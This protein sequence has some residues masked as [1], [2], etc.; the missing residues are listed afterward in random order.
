[1]KYIKAMSLALTV[2]CLYMNCTK[3]GD[4]LCK[5]FRSEIVQ[6][7]SSVLRAIGYGTPPY[8]YEWSTGVHLSETS[9]SASGTYFVVVTD[10]NNCTA[11]SEFYYSPGS[12]DTAGV[13]DE[14]NNFYKV[15]TIGTQCWLQ[16]NL[17]STAGF[18]EVKDSL[19]W[20]KTTTPAWCY[21]RN[22][23]NY[24]AYYG[25]L[26]NGYAMTS[27][28]LCPKG[29]HIPTDAEWTILINNLGG[30]NVA[31]EKMKSTSSLWNNPNVANDSSRFSV[32]PAGRVQINGSF[33]YRN[34]Q[35]GIWTSTEITPGSNDYFYRGFANSIKNVFRI[36]WGKGY[37]FSCRCIK[38]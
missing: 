28:K 21:Y 7:S 16:S 8:S 10:F 26:Y 24:S 31:G 35:A 32:F 20:S 17:R 30:D 14:E 19:V 11:R 25:K 33:I 6:E 12:C 29:W 38:N 27:G 2:A 3:K 15:I 36:S 37:G 1:M 9:V 5:Y 18:P 34:D 13:Y 4:E 23:T 22:D